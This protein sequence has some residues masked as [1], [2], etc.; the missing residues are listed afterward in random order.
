VLAVPALIGFAWLTIAIAR[1]KT[2][3]ARWVAFANPLA[4]MFAASLVDRALPQPFAVLLSGAG[5][6][7][8]M[9]AFFALST[10]VLWTSPFS[11]PQ[12]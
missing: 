9:L 7:L 12:H 6:S 5:L 4:C 11:A 10:A 3:Y 2:L 8:G 1:G